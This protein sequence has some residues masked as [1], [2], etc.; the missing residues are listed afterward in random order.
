MIHGQVGRSVPAGDSLMDGFHTIQMLRMQGGGDRRNITLFIVM[1]QN[2]FIAKDITRSTERQE[3][4]D[5][6]Q[7]SRTK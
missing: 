7:D 6:S 4:T 3:L 2:R 1:L 5:L